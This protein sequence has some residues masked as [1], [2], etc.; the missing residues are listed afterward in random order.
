MLSHAQAA[1]DD[2]REDPQSRA[3]APVGR[4][5][6]GRQPLLEP[7]DD[8]V[9]RAHRG[10][11]DRIG[12][13]HSR[14]RP[15]G[16]D[17]EPAQAEEI[18]A[19]VRLRIEALA[20]TACARPDENAADLPAERRPDLGP[21]DVEDAPDRPLERLERDVPVKP[22]VTTT[23]A[24]PSSSQRLSVF[25]AKRSSLE[26]SSSCASSVSWLPF[27]SSS[28][29]ESSRTSGSETPRISSAKTAPM[30]ANWRRCSGRASAL[31]PASMRTLGPVGP[32]SPPRSRGGE[33]PAG[34]GCGAVRRRAWRRC[35]PPTRP[36]RPLRP[37]PP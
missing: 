11:T 24:S 12:D 33:H 7:L 8:A 32:G 13:R 4:E 3:G 2:R 26:R 17:D 16:D 6:T 34:A 29:I 23:S 25:P 1:L 31:A 19:A 5:H 9:L 10:K 36:R 27:S 21:K 37:R 22:S 20:E 15:V 18:G 35:S 14:A 28:P 30:C